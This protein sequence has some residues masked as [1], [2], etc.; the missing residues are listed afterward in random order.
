M[1]LCKHMEGAGLRDRRKGEN[2]EEAGWE[3][4]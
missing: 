3:G 2:V 1:H 4:K